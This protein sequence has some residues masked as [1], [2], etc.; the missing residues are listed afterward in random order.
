MRKMMDVH[1]HCRTPAVLS[2]L[3]AALREGPAAT[4]KPAHQA[5]IS[6]RASGARGR[7]GSCQ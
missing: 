3:N 2:A 6:H 1:E 4:F 5:K 7:C